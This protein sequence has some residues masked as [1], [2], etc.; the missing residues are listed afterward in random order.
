MSY[1]VAGIA[2]AAAIGGLL[3]A[4]SKD[5]K[6]VTES[7]F[8]P[9]TRAAQ[10]EITRL[11]SEIFSR[12]FEGDF[13]APADAAELAGFQ[14]QLDFSR[15]PEFRNF[16][17]NFSRNLFEQATQLSSLGNLDPEQN[18]ALGAQLDILTGSTEDFFRQALTTLNAG[19]QASG[20]FG[21]TRA[22]I[23]GTQL[24]GEAASA[25]ALARAQILANERNLLP[26]APGLFTAGAQA[27]LLPGQL[28]ANVGTAFRGFEQLELNNELQKF[29]FPQQQLQ[30]RANLLGQFL[31]FNPTKITSTNVVSPAQKF[32]QGA[33]GGASIGS[34]IFGGGGGGG[35]T[36]TQPPQQSGQQ[37]FFQPQPFRFNNQ[38]TFAL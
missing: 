19:A 4:A 9:R 18:A 8:D 21:G 30:A 6:Q 2:A 28:E 25:D 14:Q 13:I 29:L 37:Q 15:D 24:A 11:I 33:A 17:A 32:L 3:G 26:L 16:A 38:E 10:D 22:A 35:Q 12:D 5:P 27:G 23:E 31:N 34:A 1:L 36:L 7:E 20:A